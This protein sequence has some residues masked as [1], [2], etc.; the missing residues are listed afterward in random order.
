MI[1]LLQGKIADI[2]L[3][4]GYLILDVHGVGYIIHTTTETMLNSKQGDSLRVYTHLAVRETAL[5][6]YGFINESH[7]RLFELLLSV[8]GV[9]PKSAL[10]ILSIADESTIYT[11]VST[12]ETSYLTKVSGIG[13]KLAGKIVLELKDKI[14]K[15]LEQPD[16]PTSEDGS[17]MEALEV[18]GYKPVEAREA[19]KNIP[20]DAIGLNARVAEA[21]KLLSK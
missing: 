11:A 10:S 21:L 3:E 1:G 20:S 9:G 4:K 8:S 5:D 7:K 15:Q 16:S 6:L 12:N 14:G 13:K 17:V 18:M 2:V 19:I